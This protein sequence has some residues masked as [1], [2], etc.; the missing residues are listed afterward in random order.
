[1]VLKQQIL[2]NR[3]KIKVKEHKKLY[4][5]DTGLNWE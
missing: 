5:G 1:M 2:S 4:F 3:V